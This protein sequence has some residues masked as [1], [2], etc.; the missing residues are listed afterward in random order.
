M[1]FQFPLPILVS[2]TGG[3]GPDCP[4]CVF[5]W[6]GPTLFAGA[7]AT[8]ENHFDRVTGSRSGSLNTRQ[9]SGRAL[10]HH[11]RHV[12]FA[13]SLH[14]DWAMRAL[15]ALQQRFPVAHEPPSSGSRVD[16]PLATA[17]PCR[18]PTPDDDDDKDHGHIS[19]L[20]SAY[21]LLAVLYV[22][23]HYTYHCTSTIF[24]MHTDAHEHTFYC[25]YHCTPAL[26][27]TPASAC[28][29]PTI[30]VPTFCAIPAPPQ[31]MA[32]SPRT[33]QKI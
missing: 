25:T 29:I 33:R 24:P 18:G 28:P 9:A 3:V 26:P 2:K 13:Q 7:R 4:P 17:L 1:A 27:P 30:P 5:K 16:Q 21:L 19:R 11:H 20:S 22:H 10:K 14:S 15:E 23:A 8:L 6:L 12:G 31:A 32:R